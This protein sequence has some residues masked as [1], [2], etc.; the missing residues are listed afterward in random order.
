MYG[1]SGRNF[2]FVNE[3][4]GEPSGM[5]G[6]T[7]RVDRSAPRLIFAPTVVFDV[8][9]GCKNFGCVDISECAVRRNTDQLK[10]A[11]AVGVLTML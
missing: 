8:R 6:G 1:S 2:V 10:I 7:S 9:K 3:F 5:S 4:T 11:S